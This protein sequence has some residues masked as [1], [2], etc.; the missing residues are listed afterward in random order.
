MPN[1]P[2]QLGKYLIRGELGQGGFGSVYLGLD[3]S[4]GRQVAIKVLLSEADPSQ[5]VRFR[6][7]AI[8]AGG[9]NHPNIVTIY[10]FGDDQGKFYLVMEYLEGTSLQSVISEGSLTLREKIRVMTQVAKGLQCAHEHGI[11]HRD[12]KPA[13]IMILTSGAVKV[14]DFGIARLTSEKASRVTQA[15]FIV[16]T[17]LYMA[18]EQFRSEE[19]DA[20]SD[21]WAF[22]AIYYE[23]LG[24]RHPF[25]S[26]GNVS[27][28]MY[29]IAHEEPARIGSIAPGCP[30]ALEA[31]IVRLLSKDRHTRYQSL[32]EVLDDTDA[33]LAEL[34]SQEAA[35]LVP[36]AEELIRLGRLDQAAPLLKEIRA[37]DRSQGAH[38]LRSARV[39]SLIERAK[40]AGAEG[41][42]AGAII[43]LESVLSLVPGDSQATALLA[44]LQTAKWRFQDAMAHAEERAAKQS[45]DE[46]IEVLENLT[47]QFPGS[48]PARE[49]LERVRRNRDEYRNRIQADLTKVKGLLAIQS[50]DEAIAE[51]EGLYREAPDSDEVRVE[52]ELARWQRQEYN[53]QRLIRSEIDTAREELKS[54]QFEAAIARLEAVA[55]EESVQTEV[56]GLL[57]YA[58]SE[59]EAAWRMTRIKAAGAK[60]WTLF[61]EQQFDQA[62]AEVDAALF[63]FRDEPA[64]L[65]LREAI[66]SGQAG[67]ER[68]R[69]IQQALDESA[70][71]KRRG[72]SEQACASL[73]RALQQ[74]PG[75]SSLTAALDDL[76]HRLSLQASLKYQ[77]E[78]DSRADTKP[79]PWEVPPPPPPSAPA[80]TAQS[81]PQRALGFL[82]WARNIN[83][84]YWVLLSTLLF[85]L[86]IF[87][88]TGVLK[89]PWSK[90]RGSAAPV[91][92]RVQVSPPE[93]IVRIL[94]QDK[95]GPDEIG[96]EGIDL[97]PGSYDLEAAL[98]GFRSARQ[99]VMIR[100]QTA[101]DPVNFVLQP[102]PP[103]LRIVTDGRAGT[104]S[105][106]NA[107]AGE[108][109]E[110]QFS[111]ENAAG[112][113]QLR[114][115]AGSMEAAIPFDA[116]PGAAPKLTE[117][118]LAKGFR[119]VVIGSFRGRGHVYCSC[120]QAFITLDGKPAGEI[121]AGGADLSITP[122][123]HELILDI[124]KRLWKTDVDVAAA[125]SLFA[126][127]SSAAADS[128]LGGLA[129]SSTSGDA[130]VFGD[131][132]VFVDGQ[133]QKQLSRQKTTVYVY[134]IQAGQHTV[135][136]EKPGYQNFD[137]MVAVRK[138]HPTAIVVAFKQLAAM[139]TVHF[140]NLPAGTRV[141]VDTE[142]F[143]TGP[144]GTVMLPLADV[145][146]ARRIL[147]QR[148]G[149]PPSLQSLTHTGGQ[150]YEAR[151]AVLAVEDIPA[152]PPTPVVTP[153]SVSPSPIS[154]LPSPK[155]AGPVGM[156][157]WDKPAWTGP[158]REWFSHKGSG[159]VLFDRPPLGTLVFS[160]QRVVGL[161]IPG[162]G[163][164]RIK[165]VLGYLDSRNYE[166]FSIDKDFLY[167]RSYANGK[168]GRELK[169][170]HGV[171][172][173]DDIYVLNISLTPGKLVQQIA[174]GKEWKPLPELLP[175]GTY[176]GTGK[177]GFSLE[178]NEE[179]RLGNFSFTPRSEP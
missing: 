165:W 153:P 128:N 45:F 177:F 123:H 22:G 108:L 102:L 97:E 149:S 116:P 19:A 145:S 170:K 47:Y 56:A 6:K 55:S 33:I 41:N 46:A 61:K 64:L 131:M 115:K 135:R 166:L 25:D 32:R 168:P 54:N 34:E 65:R 26:G 93:A 174:A 58:R 114:V 3:P 151:D 4:I 126:S 150:D 148:P 94:A 154:T 110:G 171:T 10:D 141:L 164:S 2:N 36:Q 159:I 88:T 104:V 49:L 160:A 173:K 124:D 85:V 71:W 70:D 90:S 95:N 130:Q 117:S 9:L 81:V 127:L 39:Q 73:E 87:G 175:P 7:E 142:S 144:D 42:F 176:L 59:M 111:L 139:A 169:Q 100:S 78:T 106:D 158:E 38:L 112:Q 5:L 113:H 14:M 147:V 143:S 132:Q 137:A 167:R 12:V 63:S 157:G 15:G 50:F 134:N 8:A 68:R 20:L 21:V 129:I 92:V 179:I 62:L 138:D 136:L 23:L 120:N 146:G 133:Q 51:L 37:L 121:A 48:A 162:F 43:A 161:R 18:P 69:L 122:G 118:F 84:I 83:G 98:D 86:L 11:V 1:I 79:V 67:D 24:G 80:H 28:T 89:F 76:Y 31:V 156:E 27:A 178:D 74:Y 13:N 29:R 125:P 109:Q 17:A 72:L 119:I 101:P 66:V 40:K 35:R 77:A 82:G 140:R 172:I 91:H 105:L 60:A 75:E 52:L 44:D 152:L 103:V 96:A 57:A 99:T 16:G 155:Q 53:R 163:G 30:D 107:S